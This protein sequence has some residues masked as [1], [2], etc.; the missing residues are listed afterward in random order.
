MPWNGYRGHESDV[1]D[2]WDVVENCSLYIKN[3][4]RRRLGFGARVDLSGDI[5][6][7]GGEISGKAVV[8]ASNG[9][10]TSIT[11]SSGSVASLGTV[12]VTSKPSFASMNNRLY[13][14]LGGT[15]RVSDDGTSYRNAGIAA[16]TVDPVATPAAGGVVT[17]GDHLIRYRYYDSTRKRLSNP[18]D[19]VTVTIVAGTQRID[20]DVT[21]SADSTVDQILIE[22]TPAGASTYY[23]VLNV[24]N[25]TGTYTV[26][27]AD[28]T[29]I[30]LVAASRDG[31]FGHEPP[32]STSGNF[33][34]DRLMH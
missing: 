27:E 9:D 32:Q 15:V 20:V 31:E 13:F 34:V 17:E 7:G 8:A 16:P 28:D 11:E 2:G 10:I 19:A 12:T 14:S 3:E 26:N 5:V 33:I 30:V 24:V 4:C 18:S 22:M 21:A 1:G 29:L 6:I 25:V 23:R